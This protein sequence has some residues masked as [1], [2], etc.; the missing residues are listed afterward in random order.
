MTH[1]RTAGH[2]IHPGH[3]LMKI[4]GQLSVEIN[5][6]DTTWASWEY[7]GLYRRIVWGKMQDEKDPL[8]MVHDWKRNTAVK[9][10]SWLG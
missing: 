8:W 5:T 6:N 10:S 2:H 7:L 9:L 4:P 1:P 3:F